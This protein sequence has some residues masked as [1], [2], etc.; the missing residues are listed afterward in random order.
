MIRLTV[1]GEFSVYLNGVLVGQF[2]NH[3]TDYGLNKMVTKSLNQ[4]TAEC[5]VGS[6]N[7]APADSDTALV[8]E[9]ASTTTIVAD[10][11]VYDRTAGYVGVRR[12]YSFSAGAAEG[13]L[14]EMGLSDGTSLF[15][16]QLFLDHDGNATTITVGA[17]DTLDIYCLVR[18]YW[19]ASN[20]KTAQSAVTIDGQSF[21]QSSGPVAD[22]FYPVNFSPSDSS[23]WF[24]RNAINKLNATKCWRLDHTIVDYSTTTPGIA[25]PSAGIHP[26]AV[27]MDSYVDDSFEVTFNL[28]WY[29]GVYTDNQ[30]DFLCAGLETS[31][32]LILFEIGLSPGYNMYSETEWAP[33]TS[34]TVGDKFI[35]ALDDEFIYEVTTGG[36][37]HTAAPTWPTTVGGTV[38]DGNGVEYECVAPLLYVED[39][40]ALVL[41]VTFSWGRAT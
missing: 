39:T 28:E 3:V 19:A 40:E 33:S 35:S 10:S 7:T 32:N 22:F 31:W 6:G 29:A 5:H 20:S 37:S 12:K 15:N 4:L 26:S 17:S 9:I 30:A 41:N 23:V 21:S 14:A 11:H 18:V 1:G 38:T 25:Y 13:T 36:T 34:Y 16:R 27:S 8:S 24:P 2:H